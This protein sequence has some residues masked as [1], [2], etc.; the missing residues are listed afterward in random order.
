MMIND[1]E[2]IS[3]LLIDFMECDIARGNSC[4]KFFGVLKYTDELIRENLFIILW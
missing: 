1:T 2:L 3:E 4:V